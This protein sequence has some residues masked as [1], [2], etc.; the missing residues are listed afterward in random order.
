MLYRLCLKL[1][2]L[3]PKMANNRTNVVF[4]DDQREE[5]STHF[6]NVSLQYLLIKLF[7][8]IILFN[9]I[10]IFFLKTFSSEQTLV[11]MICL[12]VSKLI[13]LLIL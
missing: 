8:I 6:Q 2:S 10:F 7:L 5:L 12:I 13:L 9:I 4:T 1:V 11:L 3:L